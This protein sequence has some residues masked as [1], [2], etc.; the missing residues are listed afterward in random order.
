MAY[1]IF[2]AL[3]NDPTRADAE[4]WLA[5]LAASDFNYHLDDSPETII[6]GRTGAALF[7]ADQCKA[8]ARNLDA[9]S[10]VMDWGA[11]WEFY[12]SECQKRDDF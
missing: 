9:V 1:D 2:G 3:P 4:A 8:I 7:T 11:V 6:N 12:Y 10:S 5:A